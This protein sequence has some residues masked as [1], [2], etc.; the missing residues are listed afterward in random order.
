MRSAG[1]IRLKPDV[2]RKYTSRGRPFDGLGCGM[3]T[4]LLPRG[5]PEWGK[6]EIIMIRYHNICTRRYSRDVRRSQRMQL[7]RVGTRSRDS[8]LPLSWQTAD[9]CGR[10]PLQLRELC[11]RFMGP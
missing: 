10:L 5:T 11:T 1:R 3:G 4:G 9:V 8:T 6:A 2:R 7:C